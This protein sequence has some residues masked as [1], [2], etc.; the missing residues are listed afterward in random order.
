MYERFFVQYLGSSFVLY[1][2]KDKRIGVADALFILVWGTSPPGGASRRLATSG[3]VRQECQWIPVLSPAM[4]TTY[5]CHLEVK[6]LVNCSRVF[7]EEVN[8]FSFVFFYQ[9]FSCI[10]FYVQVSRS[11]R[12]AIF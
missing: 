7:T 4:Q 1:V 5:N 2:R 6:F 11:A 8:W 9:S 10:G 12:R 3:E